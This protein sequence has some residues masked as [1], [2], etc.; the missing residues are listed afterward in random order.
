MLAQKELA[1]THE[2]YIGQEREAELK[3]EYVNGEIFAMSGAS[4]YH[5]KISSNMVASLVNQ[6]IQKEC[7]V[8]SSD[9][10]VKAAK[11]DAYTYPD[12]AVACESEQFEDEN[13]DVL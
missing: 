1:V 3:S 4:R 6:L 7:S 5:N 11:A 2:Q 13:T 12:I 9:M 10:K 8:Y